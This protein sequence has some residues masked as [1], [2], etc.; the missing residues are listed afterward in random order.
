MGMIEYKSDLRKPP[1]CTFVS[2]LRASHS[3]QSKCT[4][5]LVRLQ[6]GRADSRRISMTFDIKVADLSAEIA[7]F[8]SRSYGVVAIGKKFS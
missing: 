6:C 4:I 5:P 3:A 1:N 2:V 8:A 7:P